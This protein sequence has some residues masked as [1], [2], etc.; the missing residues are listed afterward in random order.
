MLLSQRPVP[1]FVPN[2]IKVCQLFPTTKLNRFSNTVIQQQESLVKLINEGILTQQESLF[3]HKPSI[4][5]ISVFAPSFSSEG[6]EAN[7]RA[8]VIRSLQLF[9]GTG[10]QTLLSSSSSSSSANSTSS[11][12]PTTSFSEAV[13]ETK[14]TYNPQLTSL[15][16][17]PASFYCHSSPSTSS[18]SPSSSP[19]PPCSDRAFLTSSLELAFDFAS[20]DVFSKI[21]TK[22]KDELF[23]SY[24]NVLSMSKLQSE[25][26]EFVTQSEER[27]DALKSVL[28][29]MK[30]EHDEDKE[31]VGQKTNVKNSDGVN[32]KK[33][34]Q[35]SDSNFLVVKTVLALQVDFLSQEALPIPSETGPVVAAR[36]QSNKSDGT[37]SL[38]SA[39][40]EGCGEGEVGF[41]FAEDA[42]VVVGFGGE[43]AAN[44]QRR[45]ACC[46]SYLHA[47]SFQPCYGLLRR[48]YDNTGEQNLYRVSTLAKIHFVVAE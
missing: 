11:V 25:G 26:R 46:Y 7:A 28:V 6:K 42:F 12:P 45:A 41:S 20:T 30:R 29:E 44:Q 22:H 17:C 21:A 35:C 2:A 1:I 5:G 4:K 48:S 40:G 27:A 31:E 19:P 16:S 10:G 47:D 38:S 3:A 23:K 33:T 24:A 37:T 13:Q 36:W 18:S 8:N 43:N 34:L 15:L 32:K 14:F 9:H 39:A